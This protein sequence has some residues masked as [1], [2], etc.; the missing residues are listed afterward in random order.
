MS[1]VHLH[2]LL[3]HVPAV[4][5]PLVLALLVLAV[6][7][8]SAELARAAL[9]LTVALAAVT[10]GVYLTGESAE[11][12]VERLAD[13][14]A[15]LVERHEAVAYSSVVTLSIAG[16]ASLAALVWFRRRALPRTLLTLGVV[17]SVVACG[18]LAVTAGLGGQIRHTELRGADVGSPATTAARAPTP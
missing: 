10:L 7:R 9:G 18:L 16:A 3:N 4:G 14:D 11:A 2:L 13:F 1:L 12:L 5:M 8:R 6:W 15:S 17:Y